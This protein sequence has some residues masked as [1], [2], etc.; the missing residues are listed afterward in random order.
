M[1]CLPSLLCVVGLVNCNL[2]D[3][4]HNQDSHEVYAAT[5]D[6][7][8]EPLPV[9]V[10]F[11][12]ARAQLGEAL[13]REPLLSG[14][15]KVACS[16]CHHGD[17]GL[18]EDKAHSFVE[19]RPESLVNTP[20][21]YN[22]RFLYKLG[23]G[24]KFDSLETQLDALMKNPSVMA[25]SW[26]G[27]ARR[28]SN[29]A[30]YS[31]RFSTLFHDGLTP[32]NVRQALLEY[33]RSLVTPNAPFDRF[34]RG[35]SSALSPEAKAG[36][37]LFKGYGCASCHQGIAIGGN[38]F[39]RF[40]VLRDVFADRGHSNNAD[41]GRFNVTGREQ[42]RYVFRVPSLRNVALTAPYFH[43]G[44]ATSLEQ[45]VGVMARYQLGREL[46]AKDRD[47]LVLFLRSLTG[48]YRG[49]AP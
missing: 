5:G 21:M 33:E 48:E 47:L 17:H 12:P 42:D 3:K 18:A 45:A 24:G 11:D 37:G 20:T 27:A 40:G 26:E 25:S 28:L 15:G 19:G 7:P 35:D 29:V 22:I 41:L 36:Y 32:A 1:T 31:D 6:Q 44:S 38:V 10:E 9:T 23:W 14:D 34:L 16:N 30:G 43:D 39:E 49:K 8:I 4:S 2:S 46:D 13:F